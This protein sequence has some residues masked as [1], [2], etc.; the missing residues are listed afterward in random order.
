MRIC[1]YA[2]HFLPLL[3]G[4]ETLAATLARAWA[5]LGHEVILVSDT[6][7]PQG[8]DDRFPFPVV[9]TPRRAAWAGILAGCDFIF[10]IGPS[11]RYVDEW[12]RSALPFGWTHQ[13]G[14]ARPGAP[15]APDMGFLWRRA[16]KWLTNVADLETCASE[17]LRRRLGDPVV[18]VVHNAFDPVFR[19]MPQIARAGHFLFLGRFVMDKG[20]D[21]LVEAAAICRGRGVVVEV[22]F[23]GAG[24][25]KASLAAMVDARGLGDRITIEPGL[26]GEPLA[27]A[28]NAARCI[29]V[30]SH[31]GEVFGIVVAEAFACGKCVIASADGGIPE[32]AGGAALLLPPGDAPALAAALARAARDDAL[33]AAYERRGRARAAEFTARKVALEYLAL[34][35]RAMG[36][37]RTRSLH[38]RLALAARR[39]ALSGAA[40]VNAWRRRG[41][42]PAADSQCMI[43]PRG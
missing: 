34:F 15:G 1:L 26:S 17:Y 35:E 33:V 14:G 27:A 11:L 2:N 30:P 25:E 28:V 37:R 24:P 23:M 3:G 9:R 43:G 22:K 4:M 42:P 41:I 39:G 21:T 5:E 40:R 20:I 16:R 19:P 18:R 6:P 8:Y 31:W 7:A 32:V 36:A 13:L 38:Q 10:S 29:V 12:T